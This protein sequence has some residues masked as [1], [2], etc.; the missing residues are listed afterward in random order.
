MRVS[1]AIAEIANIAPDTHQA[2]VGAAAF[3]HKAGLHAS[4]IKVDPVLYNHI[5]P[6]VVGNDMRILVTEMAGRASIELK[7]R[8]LGLDLAGHPEALSRV[9]KRVKELE[10]RGWSFEAAD[11][12]FE[13]LVRAEL[14]DERAAGRSRWS[15]TGCSSSTAR[16]AR[17]SPRRPSRSGY[18]ASGSSPPP[19]ATA[20]STRST[21][22]CGWRWPGT[23]RSCA[24]RAG[25]LQGAHPGGQPRHRRGHP[26]AGR[27]RDGDGGT[28]PRSACTRTWSRRAGTPL[29][30]ALT[31]GLSPTT[32]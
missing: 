28:G 31:Y 26:G 7:C 18:A 12:S 3:A 19:R 11:A 6:V 15:R 10:A 25:R 5:D 1:H 30:D 17:W 29:V 9:T 21:R 13:L 4:A 20:R 2:Y 27:D 8:E 22:R 14:P 32:V 16:T 23:T 24:L